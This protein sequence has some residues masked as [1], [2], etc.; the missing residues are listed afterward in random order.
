MPTEQE[1]IY[2][3]DSLFEISA[4]DSRG[5]TRTNDEKVCENPLSSVANDKNSESPLS[6]AAKERIKV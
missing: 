4:A 1:L 2:L 5:Q 6:S 3:D